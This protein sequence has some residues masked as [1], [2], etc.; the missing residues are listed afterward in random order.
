MSV[1]KDDIKKIGER[2]KTPRK[3]S[4]IDEI[5]G[6]SSEEKKVKHKR[7]T[8]SLPEDIIKTLWMLKA[9]KGYP[10][11]SRIVVEAVREFARNKEKE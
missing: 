4:Y 2:I 6:K 1:K 9:E 11:I 5:A 10:S 3:T 7:V 8:L